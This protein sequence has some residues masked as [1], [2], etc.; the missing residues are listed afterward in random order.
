M[1][2]V[3]TQTQPGDNFQ[4]RLLSYFLGAGVIFLVSCN[5]FFTYSGATLYI[6]EPVYAVLF[7][8]AV[9]FAIAATLLALPNVKGLGRLIMLVVYA[10]S[11]IH[12]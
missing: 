8:I 7:A 6:R 12:I 9:Q 5:G 10:L 3:N 2:H 4:S 1:I 11:L